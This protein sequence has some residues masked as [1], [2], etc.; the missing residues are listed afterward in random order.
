MIGSQ[1]LLQKAQA[2]KKSV[3]TNGTLLILLAVA[4]I[5]AIGAAIPAIF[6]G[7]W[8]LFACSVPKL[9][10]Y[11][12]FW[13]DTIPGTIFIPVLFICIM[14]VYDDL[15]GDGKYP[16]SFWEFVTERQWFSLT[17]LC[18]IVVG[19]CFSLLAGLALMVASA[20]IGAACCGISRLFLAIYF[21]GG[22]FLRSLLGSKE[23]TEGD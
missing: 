3:F 4:I 1:V 6:W 20:I 11:S 23:E 10:G 8:Y 7:I 16:I 12:R 14:D 15:T 2:G 19:I 9:W 13:L 5:A 21:C 22:N 18:L 17:C